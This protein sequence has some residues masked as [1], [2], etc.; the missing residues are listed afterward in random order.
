MA[1]DC[2]TYADIPYR[3]ADFDRMIADPKD[4]IE[5]DAEKNRRLR[6]E[7]AELGGD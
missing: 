2:F 1:S 5:L 6:A 3:I 4:T 7:S